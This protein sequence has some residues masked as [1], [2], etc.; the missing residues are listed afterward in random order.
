MINTSIMN[1]CLLTKW[2]WKIV[3]GSDDT[4]FKVLQAKYMRNGSFFSSS[5]RGTS[6]FWQ[7]LHKVKHLFK[8]GAIYQVQDGAKTFFWRIPG[9][10]THQ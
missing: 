9:K 5:S 8:W 7:S 1:E 4:W 3:K 2:I 6:Q 10:G